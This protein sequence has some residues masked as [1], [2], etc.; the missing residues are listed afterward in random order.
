MSLFSRIGPISNN[1]WIICNASFC[2][3][4]VYCQFHMF[5]SNFSLDSS[6]FGSIPHIYCN[7]FLIFVMNLFSLPFRSYHNIFHAEPLDQPFPIQ[8]PNVID[9]ISTHN[10]TSTQLFVIIRNLN[11]LSFFFRFF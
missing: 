1:L 6:F 7:Y 10:L 5:R 3:P 11:V 2:V 9:T 4:H 8:I